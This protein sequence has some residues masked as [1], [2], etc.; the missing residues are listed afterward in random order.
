MSDIIPDAVHGMGLCERH[1]CV[2]LALRGNTV[3]CDA[4]LDKTPQITK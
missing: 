2:C 3:P 4:A 1:H